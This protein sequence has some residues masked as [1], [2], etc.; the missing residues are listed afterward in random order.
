MV[1]KTHNDGL[2]ELEVRMDALEHAKQFL[3]NHYD[4][5]D[6][7]EFHGIP[8]EKFDKQDL[9]RIIRVSV[10][11]C[12]KLKKLSSDTSRLH[13]MVEKSLKITLTTHGQDLS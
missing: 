12:D 9:L 4:D 7:I 1:E 8:I 6:I 10:E 3:Q 5:G 13:C 11:S 2:R